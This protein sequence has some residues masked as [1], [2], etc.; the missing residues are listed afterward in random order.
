MTKSELENLLKRKLRL[1]HPTFHLRKLG[2]RIVGNVISD[3]FKGLPS[4][5]R[6]DMVWETLYAAYGPEI[7]E[8]VGSV[9]TYTQDEWN[10]DLPEEPLA[11]V[12]RTRVGKHRPPTLRR[13]K[14]VEA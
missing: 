9:L 7:V 6:L 3:T 14:R 10:M 2:S 1:K 8:K 12:I 5:Q 11:K 13:R 4:R